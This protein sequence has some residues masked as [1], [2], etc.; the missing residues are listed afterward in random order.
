MTKGMD[1]YEPADVETAWT[2][3]RAEHPSMN[4][5]DGYQTFRAGYRRGFAM[6]GV[7]SSTMFVH[8]TDRPPDG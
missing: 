2:E 4:N 3:Y 7:V 8:T 5:S 1:S 6:G